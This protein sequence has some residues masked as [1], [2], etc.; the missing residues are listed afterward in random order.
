MAL[1][2]N[3][4]K[5]K[6]PW[7]SFERF[8]LDEVTTVKLVH[9]SPGKRLSLQYHR[10]RSEFWRVVEGAGTVTIGETVCEATVGDE[11]E[12]PLETRHRLAGGEAGVTVLEIAFGD[13]DESDIVRIDD[14][15]GR[16]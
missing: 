3:R 2:K 1:L 5:E 8:T 10:K 15:F 9:V 7:G 11:F 13:F 16:A 6:R 12:I 4:D 14:D